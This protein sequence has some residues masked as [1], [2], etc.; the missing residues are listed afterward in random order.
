LKTTI[1]LTD[2]MTLGTLREL[3]RTLNK[4]LT[5]R[6]DSVRSRGPRSQGRGQRTE[7]AD[8]R[9]ARPR[10]K[11]SA[12]ARAALARNLAKARAARAAKAEARKRPAKHATRASTGAE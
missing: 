2:D 1:E 12:K 10:R 4:E 3:A 6:F 5:L 8:G 11:L 9:A 7:M